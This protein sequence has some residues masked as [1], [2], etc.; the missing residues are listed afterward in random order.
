MPLVDTAPELP[1]NAPITPLH[2]VENGDPDLRAKLLEKARTLLPVLRQRVAD[3]EAA[4]HIHPDTI[5][6]F[7]RA[8]FWRMLQ[9]SMFDGLEVHPNTFF[10]VQILV[11]SA[12]PSAAW[13]L[14]VVAVHNW[15]LALFNIKAQ[16]EVWGDDPSVLISSSYAPTGKVETVEGGYRLTGKWSF[17]SGVDHCK[18]AFLGG[19]VPT[20]GCGPP[21]M[22]T[23]LVPLSEATI[24]DN[25]HTMALK[26]TGSK[27]VI[28]DGVFV[29]EHRTHKMSDGF[30]C[31][32]PG[33][34]HHEAPLYRLPFGQVFVR[35]VSTT[36]I[37]IA[38]GALAFYRQVTSTKVGAADGNRASKDPSSQMACARAASTI[39]QL[40]LV[41]H[42]NMAQLMADA[43]SGKRTDIDTRVAYRWDSSEA[44][45]KAVAVV[46]ELFALC[47]AR[48]LFLS[49]PMHRYFS[50]VH[51][52]RAHYANR[53]DASGRNFGR[54][55][56][57]MRT[58][59][60]FI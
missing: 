4:R 11:A 5:E 41:L 37:G 28:L 12:H 53:P 58:T 39:D 56:L 32:N 31:D 20:D 26:A 15:Q 23:F 42:R 38:K 43:A 30:R 34:A 1:M 55:Q 47:G 21:D 59:D 33:N 52:A 7:H 16:N 17:S 9:P 36:S 10:D 44:V 46:D 2:T 14:G 57:G 45:T 27:D 24:D 49:S 50:D 51:G 25:W 19:F 60:Y 18:W 48:A 6:D 35:S 3:S 29:P 13:V 8:G 22:R 40:E 54:V